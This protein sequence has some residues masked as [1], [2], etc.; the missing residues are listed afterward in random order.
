MRPSH[1]P[2][3]GK[4]RD[5]SGWCSK[6]TRFTSRPCSPFSVPFAWTPRNSMAILSGDCARIRL[7]T[8]R[9][10]GSGLGSFAH[11]P[12]LYARCPEARGIA[13]ETGAFSG[14]RRSARTAPREKSR[15]CRDSLT[16]GRVKFAARGFH[17]AENLYRRACE[18]YP[19]YGAAWFGLAETERR[20]G[21]G[22]ESDKNFRLAE[23][24][25]DR[26]PPSR[27]QLLARSPETGNRHRNAPDRG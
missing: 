22:A 27:D 5:A 19:T 10:A 25:K 6:H 21:H 15:L 12:G 3:A 20:L 26:N 1:S 18:A 14:K 2:K 13:F 8:G 4:L 17:A 16:L 24:Y 9:S 7:Q 11:P 23:S